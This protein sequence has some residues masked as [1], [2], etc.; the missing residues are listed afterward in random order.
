MKSD[1]LTKRGLQ[2]LRKDSGVSTRR[3]RKTSHSTAWAAEATRSGQ[4]EKMG[5]WEG[6]DDWKQLAWE[7]QYYFKRQTSVTVV[8]DNHSQML[9]KADKHFQVSAI[10]GIKARVYMPGNA[11]VKGFGGTVFIYANKSN[12]P[13]GKAAS[14]TANPSHTSEDTIWN[15]INNNNKKRT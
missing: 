14:G 12:S 4:V 9:A 3:G 7:S 6:C 10:Q 8:K 11:Y 5:L 1:T 13:Q 2:I 15:C